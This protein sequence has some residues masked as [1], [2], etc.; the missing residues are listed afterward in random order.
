MKNKFLLFTYIWLFF[1][2]IAPIAS[3]ITLTV[4]IPGQPNA[5][6]DP[7]E[8]VRSLY[9][10]GRVAVG[11][12]AF[13]VIVFAALEYAASAGNTA[14]QEDARSRIKEAIMGIILLFGATLVFN[15][16][17]PKI[18]SFTNPTF[19]TPETFGPAAPGGTAGPGAGPQNNLGGVT[20]TLNQ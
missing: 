9:N 11:A 19:E 5:G 20:P 15:L 4:K 16:I 6:N 3:A 7:A 1:L 8:Y 18:L 2:L 13:G 17:N 10:F 14:R 12:T